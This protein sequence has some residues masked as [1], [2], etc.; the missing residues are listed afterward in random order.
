MSRLPDAQNTRPD[1]PTPEEREAR[2][3]ELRAKRHARA[4]KIAIRSGVVTGG[5]L[6]LVVA[7]AYW[8][9]TTIA[10]RDLLLAQIKARLPANA[11]LE[12]KDAEGPASGP[13]TLH[14]VR[15]RWNKL[16]FDAQRVTLDPALRPL[17]GRRLRLDAMQ[18]ENATLD[19]PESDEP[20]ELPRWPDSLPQITV[21]LA[22][23][24]DD[25]RVDGLRITRQAEPLIEIRRLRGGVDATNGRLALTR[26]DVDSDRGRFSAHGTYAPVEHYRT[27]LVATALVPARNSNTPMRLGFVARG[28]LDAMDVALAGAAPG[29]VRATL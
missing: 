2:I 20:F 10:G 5:V 9:L 6:L 18:V 4:K 19:L 12:W 21:P 27:D 24:A 3:R 22:L 15:F 11:S 23:Q 7:F 13:L 28:D 8:L 1:G 29:P 16:A 14:D 25:I 17:L 26:V